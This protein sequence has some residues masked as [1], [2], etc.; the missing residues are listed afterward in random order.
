MFLGLVERTGKFWVDN[1]PLAGGTNMVALTITDAAGNSSSTNISVVQS[2]LLLTMNP[3]T[4]AS[5][6]W[7]PTV[8]VSG[9]IS[10]PSYAVWVN[11]VKASNPGNGTWTATNVP[12]TQGGAAVFQMTAYSPDEQ[13]PDGSYGK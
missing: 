3:V 12:V 1:I 6:L 5:Q 11:G 4:P 7:Q 10:D 13:Q 8:N 9:T 2:A